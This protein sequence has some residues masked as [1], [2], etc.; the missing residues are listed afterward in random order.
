MHLYL[1]GYRGSGKTSVARCLA[2]ALGVEAIDLDNLIAQAAGCSIPEIFAS[3][4]EAGFRDRES[5]AL[6]SI[7]GAE[8][9]IVALGGGAIFREPN[10]QQIKQTGRCIWL[11]ADASTLA[12][13]IAADE[14]SGPQRPGLTGSGIN[15]AD[16]VAE[17]LR[18]REPLY[19][20]AADHQIT[21]DSKP[22]DEITEEIL[23][24]LDT[25]LAS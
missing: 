1:T 18:K 22:I 16:E 24:W 20:Q 17:V 15:P 4:G 5:N 8:P 7:A 13:R 19:A 10:R 23:Q 3:E 21:V 11:V 14:A 25:Q 12:S 2:E 9:S 6:Q